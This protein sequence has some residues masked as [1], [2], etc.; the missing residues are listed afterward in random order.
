MLFFLS[1]DY[2]AEYNNDVDILNSTY[3]LGI[4][5]LKKNYYN[6]KI[7]KSRFYTLKNTKKNKK[8]DS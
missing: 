6:L 4:T 5:F 3:T 1:S 2:I 8:F 7:N